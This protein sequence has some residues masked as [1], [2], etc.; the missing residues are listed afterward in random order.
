[1]RKSLGLFVYRKEK[2][3]LHAYNQSRDFYV[4]PVLSNTSTKEN[5]FSAIFM[6]LEA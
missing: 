4:R 5:I 2:N 3:R 1:M 6:P